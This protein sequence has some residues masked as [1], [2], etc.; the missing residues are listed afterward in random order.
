MSKDDDSKSSDPVTR[1][2]LYELVWSE[3]LTKTAVQF[4]VP[5]S[6]LAQACDSLKVPRPAPGYWGKLA[7]GRAPARPPLPD[8][9]VQDSSEWT[10]GAALAPARPPRPRKVRTREAQHASR[11]LQVPPRYALTRRSASANITFS[12]LAWAAY[13]A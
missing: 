6:Q 13:P 12:F 10:P 4:G 9:D 7:A 5:A 8:I 11:Y 1:E 3:P 2:R